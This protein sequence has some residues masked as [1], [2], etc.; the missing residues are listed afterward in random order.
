[1]ISFS[2]QGLLSDRVKAAI[3]TALAMVLA[4]GVAL[5]MNWDN[6]DWAAFSVA[7]CTLSTVGESL[8]K[9][10]LRLCGTFLAILA[11]ITLIALFPQGRWQFLIGMTIFTGFCT[12]MM[13]GTSRWYFWQLAGLSV[14]LLAL[15]GGSNPLNDFQTVVTRFEETALGV[16]S[17]SL[18]WL[19]I[20]PTSSRG[21]LENAVR[22]LV[23]A[24]RQLAAHYL[25]PTIGETHDADPEAF[26]QQAT[27]VLAHL[28]SLLDGAEVDSYEVWEARRAWR[29]LIRQLLQL[30]STFEHLRQSSTKEF[31]RE[32]L[33]PGLPKFAAELDRRFS[34][35]ER[36][37]EGHLPEHGPTSVPLNVE[38]KIGSLSPFHRAALLLY[39]SQL[40][41]IDK[42]TRDLFE[43]VADIRNF[44]RAEVDPAYD[45]MPL[46]SSA[47]DPERLASVARWFTGLWLAW[48]I[49]L[50]VPDLPD[51]VTFIVVINS[52]SM[53]LCVIPQVPI[54]RMFLPVAF[55]IALGGAI[56]VLVMP[57]LTSFASLGL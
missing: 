40:Q 49:A 54:A 53:A 47:L 33:I 8:N 51:T 26:R 39:R 48:F 24:Q 38:E 1:M 52:L 15:A 27:Q 34:E 37:L 17:Y 16:V 29:G 2:D 32:L 21:A 41:E 6:A 55:G 22:R 44:T 11:T 13:A 31:N 7:F 42:L 3:K 56:Y 4:Y 36:M 18:V 10:L 19:L 5:S 9:G 23:A 45:S 30:S 20:W 28:S 12:Y 14:P 46:L 25:T 35:I 57:H 50:Y 43:T